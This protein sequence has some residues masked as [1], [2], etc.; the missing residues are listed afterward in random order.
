MCTHIQRFKQKYEKKSTE[1]YQFFYNFAKILLHEHVFVM[2]SLL[3]GQQLLQFENFKRPDIGRITRKL[4]FL[5]SSKDHLVE[6][7]LISTNKIGNKDVLFNDTE[8]KIK[9]IY[10]EFLD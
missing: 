9:S 6:E 8:K 1:H 3:H 4:I 5:I 2:S 10:V 7:I